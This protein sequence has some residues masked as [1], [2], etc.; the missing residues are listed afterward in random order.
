MA[1]WTSGTL[2][3]LFYALWRAHARARAAPRVQFFDTLFIA[4]TIASLVNI[5][6]VCITY[7]GAVV[8]GQYGALVLSAIMGACAP[9]QLF[10]IFCAAAQLNARASRQLLPRRVGLAKAILPGAARAARGAWR[11]AQATANAFLRTFGRAV[12]PCS[13]DPEG[14]RMKNIYAGENWT[15]AAPVARLGSGLLGTFFYALGRAGARA[16]AGAH[17][18][19]FDP[20]LPHPP[21]FFPPHDRFEIFGGPRVVAAE[22]GRARGACA[23]ECVRDAACAPGEI[24]SCCAES[25]T[26]APATRTRRHNDHT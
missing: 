8:C 1:R 10:V 15:G 6:F 18:R 20:P 7:V 5:F 26:L 4:A 13:V 19:V 16:R 3:E 21:S 9:Y 25:V 17:A 22:A 14:S 23:R 2:R 11:G 24:C 12:G